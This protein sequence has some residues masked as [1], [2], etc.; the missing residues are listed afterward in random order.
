MA[1]VIVPPKKL[2]QARL[3]FGKPVSKSEENKENLLHQNSLK[4][5]KKALKNVSSLDQVSNNAVSNDKENKLDAH[6]VQVKVDV[7]ST[8]QCPEVST[9]I[10]SDSEHETPLPDV[11]QNIDDAINA[12]INRA[13]NDKEAFI[14]SCL[15][16]DS[17]KRRRSR[18]PNPAETIII[19]ND[20]PNP[21]VTTHL[22]PEHC[23]SSIIVPTVV[24]QSPESMHKPKKPRRSVLE[25][26][27]KGP[28]KH[29]AGTDKE[30]DVVEVMDCDSDLTEP[31]A[32]KHCT[33]MLNKEVMCI[34]LDASQPD[35][36]TVEA[37]NDQVDE[38]VNST[39]TEDQKCLVTPSKD[40]LE[41]N[42]S[43]CSP[44]S[45]K[46]QT[47]PKQRSARKV[48]PETQ[49][50]KE[51][52]ERE[53]EERKR[54][55]EEERHQKEMEKLELKRK[56][57][58]ERLQRDEEK[59]KI[60][61]ELD[62]MKEE[63]LKKKQEENE[64]RKAELEAKR[65]EK[66]QKDEERQREKEKKEAEK[67][68]KEE[69]KQKHLEEKLKLEEEKK[70]IKDKQASVFKN[71]FTS[72]SS[73]KRVLRRSIGDFV[74]FQLKEDMFLAPATRRKLTSNF[75]SSLDNMLGSQSQKELYVHE[76]K[77]GK[78]KHEKGKPTIPIK[79]NRLLS[80]TE[81]G[82]E[83]IHIDENSCSS[84]KPFKAKFLQF[85]ENNRPP[86]FGTWRKTSKVIKG[87][88]PFEKD[89]ELFDYEVDSD[90][91][92][93]DPG[94][95][96]DIANSDGEE[97]TEKDEDEDE[98]DGF[99]VPHGYLSDDEGIDADGEVNEDLSEQK[100]RIKQQEFENSFKQKIKVLSP[101]IIGCIWPDDQENFHK[102]KQQA[103]DE[104]RMMV[105]DEIPIDL[106]MTQ[107][108]AARTPRVKTE[109][110]KPAK[111]PRN[112]PEDAMPDLIRMLHGNPHSSQRLVK[113]FQTYWQTHNT[114]ASSNQG[115]TTLEVPME[116][117]AESNSADHEVSNILVPAHVKKCESGAASAVHHLPASPKPSAGKAS[118]V[119]ADGSLADVTIFTPIDKGPH[120][121]PKSQIL[122]KI[123][124]IGV[125]G[126]R[127]T[128]SRSCWFVLDEVFDK[129][130]LDRE[131]FPI[132]CC[133]EYITKVPDIK[134]IQV[135][136]HTPANA[137][138]DAKEPTQP[139]AKKMT[140]QK[141]T[142]KVS[143]ETL[144][145]KSL[146]K[147]VEEKEKQAMQTQETSLSINKFAT[148]KVSAEELIESSRQKLARQQQQGP[149][150]V[151]FATLAV[152]NA[153]CQPWE[154]MNEVPNHPAAFGVPT[155]AAFKSFFGIEM[156]ETA[157]S[158]APEEIG[159]QTTGVNEKP[160]TSAEDNLTDS[161]SRKG[162]E[163][164]AE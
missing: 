158:V 137:T 62:R 98:G 164:V 87:K 14:E 68:L 13:V 126:R 38:D 113:E 114:S 108:V 47:S 20:D 115:S 104:F 125:Y 4:S 83:V 15:F 31:V 124:E 26:L 71:F 41:P 33:V 85:S 23:K 105:F 58:E 32:L 97:E 120:W 43:A 11:E 103:L 154:E 101:V 3:S 112:V 163:S 22:S 56:R 89:T 109:T 17:K 51:E 77:C 66:E 159:V 1:D 53:K 110:S 142:A 102:R 48:N 28:D 36:P 57:E 93:E 127:D 106:E 52:K 78:R 45:N 12:V 132:P 90:D 10:H 152:G 130:S 2:K 122:K 65:L 100:L 54:L 157:K 37:N 81:D 149:R 30:E 60:K 117:E 55:K 94:E 5:I 24:I 151:E 70:R 79:R 19:D 8:I 42:T 136:E 139:A 44:T 134:I 162:I 91:E 21:V 63:R 131:K 116:T 160:G 153:Q 80:L 61:E 146:K 88:T 148:A 95:G 72:P 9:S 141:F 133:W 111:Q 64:K 75:I 118:D 147:D 99:F 49:K 7:H 140:I 18:S 74:Q 121:I 135:A 145:E 82:L 73:E 138:N 25:M 50:K 92:W 161:D 143:A 34:D 129:Y 67:K 39:K 29:A 35:T 76:I 40:K 84:V 6:A 46:K 59:R 123:K 156:G 144:L 119:M 86:Y 155:H 69:E 128:L 150:R 27:G 96:E 16:R 107:I